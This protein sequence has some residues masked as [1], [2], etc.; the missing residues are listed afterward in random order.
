MTSTGTITRIILLQNYYCKNNQLCL[1]NVKI[2]LPE[3]YNFHIGGQKM[4]A[5]IN[6]RGKNKN[7]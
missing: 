5:D 2:G 1:T 3:K 6:I 4:N 7:F